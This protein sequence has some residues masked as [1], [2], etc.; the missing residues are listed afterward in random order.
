MKLKVSL[1]FNDFPVG[2][3]DV[4]YMDPPWSYYNDMSVTPDQNK[5]TDGMSKLKYPVL[6]S[7]DLKKLPIQQIAAKDS[8]LFIWTTDYHLKLAVELIH[9]WGFTYKTVGFIWM[10]LTKS[11]IPVSFMGAYTKKSGVELCLLATKGNPHPLVINH[12][13]GSLVMSQRQEHS[14][15]PEEVRIRIDQLVGNVK[16]VELFAR[17]KSPGWVSWGN[18]L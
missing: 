9:Q 5:S 16:K 8:L 2:Q 3:F 14:R 10:K 11:G 15:K 18:E 13:V 17:S 12:K 4:I 1:L 7:E 6:G